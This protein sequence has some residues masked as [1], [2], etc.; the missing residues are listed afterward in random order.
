MGI[1]GALKSTFRGTRSRLEAFPL[2]GLDS[3]A[4]AVNP[5]ADSWK[6]GDVSG[7]SFV[8]VSLSV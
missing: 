8:S 6:L 3:L 4:G 1:V 2:V 5:V 7:K